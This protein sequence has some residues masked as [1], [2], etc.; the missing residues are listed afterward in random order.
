MRIITIRWTATLACLGFLNTAFAADESKPVDAAAYTN[1]IRLACIG[2]S[3]T[4]GVGANREVCYAALIQKALGSRWVV[5]NLGVSGAT[6]LRNG[7]KP[8]PKLPQYAQALELKA[9]VATIALGTN[10]SKPDNWAKK[11][12]FEADYKAMIEELRKANPKVIIYCCLPPPIG[13]NKW[14]MNGEVMKNE[15]IPLIRKVAADTKCHV[16]DLHAAFDGKNGF[17]PKDLVH[18]NDEGHTLMAAA[19]YKALTGKDIP[20]E[21]PKAEAAPQK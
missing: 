7:S 18:P 15:I 10:D 1:T 14:S 12:E 2:D 19:V 3:I 6:L 21:A 17:A 9:D 20:A 5:A 16:I 13:A 4:K 11:A 8:Y